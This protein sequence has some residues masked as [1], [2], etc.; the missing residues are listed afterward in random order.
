MNAKTIK[1]IVKYTAWL[2]Y[3]S[4]LA[5]LI[6]VTI[7]GWHEDWMLGLIASQLPLWAILLPLILWKERNSVE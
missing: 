3:I 1:L 2:S 6:G 4:L 5:F 7:R